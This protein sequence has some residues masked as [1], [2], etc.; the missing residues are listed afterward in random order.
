MLINTDINRIHKPI[1]V[2]LEYSINS[3]KLYIRIIFCYVFGSIIYT[4]LKNQLL[5]KY[6]AFEEG[7][8]AAWISVWTLL[9]IGVAEVVISTTTGSLTLLT[10]GLDSLADSLISFIVWFGITMIQ[11]PKSKLFN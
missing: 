2:D 11:K 3:I 8:K 1:T 10:D 4:T 7:K 5:S 9:G 6:L